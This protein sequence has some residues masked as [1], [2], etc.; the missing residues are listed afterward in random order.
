M[1]LKSIKTQYTK[2]VFI[3]KIRLIIS[4]VSI[5]AIIIKIIVSI[6]NV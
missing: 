6:S 1:L 4:N 2:D 5:H 3:H